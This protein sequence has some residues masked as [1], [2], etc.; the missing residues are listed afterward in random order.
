MDEQEHLIF[1][2]VFS[3]QGVDRILARLEEFWAK[4]GDH[5]GEE[6]YIESGLCRLANLAAKEGVFRSL[7]VQ[8]Q[9]LEVVKAMMGP[10]VRTSMVNDRDVPWPENRRK[11]DDGDHRAILAPRERVLLGLDD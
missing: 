11:H 9:V 5:A 2:K 10:D 4:G 7:D 3:S 6:N 8:P 1:E